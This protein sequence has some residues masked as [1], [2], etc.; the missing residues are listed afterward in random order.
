[1]C[2]ECDAIGKVLPSLKSFQ[3][4]WNLPKIYFL[5]YNYFF[6]SVIQDLV[7]IDRVNMPSSS[8]GARLGPLFS[9]AYAHR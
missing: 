5:F 3:Q 2:E 9:E 7:W 6:K 8:M 1:M 4:Q